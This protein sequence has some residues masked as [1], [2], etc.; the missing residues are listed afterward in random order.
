MKY[1]P[2]CGTEN[3]KDSVFCKKCGSK[4]RKEADI[5]KI[6]L[7]VGVFLVLFSSIFFGILNWKNMNDLFRLL[8]FVFETGL[9]FLMSLAI[10][11]VS[12]VTSRIFFIIGLVL[13]PFTLSMVP[14]YNLIPKILYNNALIFTYLAIIYLLTTVSYKLINIKFKSKLLDYLALLALLIAIIFAGLIFKASALVIGLIVTIYMLCLTI[15]SKINY[16]SSNKS[17]YVSSIILSVLLTIYLILAFSGINNTYY[18]LTGMIIGA[19]S[20][21]IFIIDGYL[22]MFKENTVMHFFTP[23]MIQLLS[24]IYIGNI[25]SFSTGGTILTLVLINIAFYFVSLLFKNKL[26][27]ITTLIL[28]YI[29]L[30]F[31]TF[32]CIIGDEY[33]WLT[34]VSA[35]FLLFNISLLAIKKYNFVHFFMAVNVLTMVVG[36]NSLLYN[37]D[38]LIIIGFLL[39]LYLI[40]Y[41]ILNLINNKFDFMYLILMLIIGFVTFI[42][43]DGEKFGVIKLIISTTFVIGFVLI[44]IFNEHVSLR[45]IWY[46]ILNLIILTL[47]NDVYYSL[48]TISIL[49]LIIGIVLQKTTKFDFKTHL[50]YAEIVTF[51]ITLFN[52][53]DHSVYSLFINVLAFI[54]GYV[55]LVNFH[56]KKPW[57]MAFI[58]VGLIY[59]FRLLTVVINPIVISSLI[60]LLIILIIIISMYLLDRYKSIELVIISLVSLIPYYSLIDGLFEY[61]TLFELYLVPFVVYSIVLIFVIKWKN[62][63]ARNVF[64]LVPFFIITLLFVIN[65]TG[66][67]STIIDAVF[68]V[69]YIIL[70]LIKKFNLLV[71]FAIGVLVLTIILQLFTVLNS[72]AAII[73]LLVVGF[74]L[75][76]VAVIYGTKKKD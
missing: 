67:I 24:F 32:V 43:Q 11:K 55:A 26:F 46:V 5:Q 62:N 17:Y 25:F 15:V 28:T 12:N 29:M 61:G 50:L 65:N 54:L 44:N 68:A 53:M 8:F 64:I 16:F 31:I 14:Y 30:A 38:S 39:I 70:G 1:C 52:G 75:I 59:I 13:T 20:L 57:K 34:I 76:F 69:T 35:I 27:S 19:I 21:T 56:N 45:I 22:K 37:F 74:V 7:L 48:L 58:M 42:L 72:M 10:K 2:K 49:T 41:L 47:F 51:I 33:L 9:F 6:V 18:P 4:F 73:A 60:A 66:V 63:T 23:F 71:F 3:K 40:I 36:L